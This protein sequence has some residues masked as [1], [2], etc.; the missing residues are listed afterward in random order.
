VEASVLDKP[1]ASAGHYV[2]PPSEPPLLEQCNFYHSIDLPGIGEQT[3]QWDLRPGIGS[4]LGPTDFSG[5]RVLEIGTAN[6]F[7]CFELERRG[8]DVVAVDLPES[9][10]YDAR[11]FASHTE[12]MRGG[13]RGIR[14]AYWL[15]HA[16][17]ESSAKVVYAHVGE[18]PDALGRFDVAVLANVLQ[19]VRDPLGALMS[20]ARKTNRLVVTEADWMHGLYEDVVGMVLFQGAAPYSWFQLRLPLV[21][22]FLAELGFA[23][24]HVDRHEQLLLSTVDYAGQ[25]GHRETGGTAVPHFTVTASRT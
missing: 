13:L 9:A 8:A 18:I 1:V 19:H 20:V 14:N 5:L 4:Y 23:K 25:P 6:G 21:T 16:L 22:T 24:Q 17:T 15:G 11:P 10:S 3:G 12:E 2:R 7:V